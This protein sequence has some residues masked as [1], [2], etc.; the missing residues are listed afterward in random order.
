MLWTPSLAPPNIK[1]QNN[2]VGPAL[3]FGIRVISI[4]H[5]IISY[6]TQKYDNQLALIWSI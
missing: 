4:I 1:P 3:A 5:I 6:P 2:L